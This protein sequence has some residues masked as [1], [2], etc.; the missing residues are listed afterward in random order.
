MGGV[1][2][3]IY[4]CIALDLATKFYMLWCENLATAW[5]SGIGFTIC[6]SD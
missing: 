6:V 3:V 5:R 1:A 4:A 2:S